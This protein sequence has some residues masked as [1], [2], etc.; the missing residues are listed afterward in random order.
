M[1]IKNL[2]RK[3]ND[4]NILVGTSGYSFED[5]RTVFYPPE[6]QKGKMLDFYSQHFPTVEINS[7]YYRIP[8]AAVFYHLANKT[9]DNFEF[10][11]KV[12][13]EVTHRY[14]KPFESLKELN[15]VVQPLIDAGKMYGYL[16]QFPWRF[17]YH[18]TKLTYIQKISTSCEPYP[19]FV[20]FRH[21]SWLRGAVYRFLQDSK[22]GYCC[23]DEPQIAGLIPPQEL[24]TSKIGYVRF[25]G[26]NSQTWWDS[27]KGDRYD[28]KYSDQEL[29]NWLQRIRVMAEKSD[30]LYLFF[31]NCHMGQ[32]IINARKMTELLQQEGLLDLN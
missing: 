30:K 1:K 22:I 10:I 19:L 15:Q 25:H 24:V 4:G 21:A 32:A 12:N 5:W 3:K 23:V 16:A 17:K 6:I 31:N 28:Y 20:E 2:N 27:S 8:H 9:P 26:R 29:Q 18:P 14:K 7:T 13:Q 11:V